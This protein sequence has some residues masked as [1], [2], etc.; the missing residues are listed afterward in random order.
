MEVLM[1]FKDMFK[2]KAEKAEANAKARQ[3]LMEK[4]EARKAEAIVM[5]RML[6]NLDMGDLG[7]YYNRSEVSHNQ[8]GGIEPKYALPWDMP[9]ENFERMVATGEFTDPSIPSQLMS[10]YGI[11]RPDTTKNMDTI[12]KAME[13]DKIRSSM[14]QE[15]ID[16]APEEG[17]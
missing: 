14:K 8:A 13:L 7:P 11:M 2:S 12:L 17:Y 5:D 3:M 10:D 15:N 16:Y 9:K 1:N 6:T 4:Q